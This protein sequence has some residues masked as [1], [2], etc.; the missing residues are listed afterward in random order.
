MNRF[1]RPLIYLLIIVIAAVVIYFLSGCEEKQVDARDFTSFK[2]T[3]ISGKT[4]DQSVFKGYKITMINFWGTFC[5]PCIEEM[6]DLGDIYEERQSKDFNIIGIVTD[7]QGEDYKVLNDMMAKATSI[8]DTTGA[9]YKHLLLYEGIISD[10]MEPYKFQGIPTTFFVDS[11]GNVIGT[12]V[13]GRKSKSAWDD[14][15]DEKLVEVSN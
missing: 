7:V 2:T 5:G 6:P 11:E 9:D 13:V 8:I 14:I 15:I 4:I 3:T 1:K 12:P 10:V